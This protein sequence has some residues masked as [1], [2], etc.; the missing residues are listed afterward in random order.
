MLTRFRIELKTNR[1]MSAK[2]TNKVDEVCSHCDKQCSIGKLLRCGRC[3][4]ARYCD[5]KCQ[6]QAWTTHKALCQP[7]PSQ[8]KIDR[9]HE[10]AMNTVSKLKMEALADADIPPL[11]ITL[12]CGRQVTIFSGVSLPFDLSELPGDFSFFMP[13]H[14][15][16]P[17]LFDDCF[18]LKVNLCN[19]LKHIGCIMNDQNAAWVK[20]V[21]KSVKK[22]SRNLERLF[23]RVNVQLSDDN[24]F[25]NDMTGQPEAV[26]IYEAF[27]CDILLLVAHRYVHEGA[28]M[29]GL[30]NLPGDTKYIKADTFFKLRLPV[31]NER[32]GYLAA[33]RSYTMACHNC[34]NVHP[35]G[36]GLQYCAGCHVVKYCSKAC[37][38]ASWREQHKKECKIMAAVAV[39]AAA[40]ET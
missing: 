8:E 13:M 9:N 35:S 23:S 32:I 19:W 25:F 28:E 33:H 1:K 17:D 16:L 38:R 26:K 6:A 11:E 21:T 36:A 40:A 39:A 31:F 24:A 2:A 20:S 14:D 27:M 30:L 18:M 5:A 34:R 12:E 22:W 4:L 29:F 37:Q 3:R 7:P 10:R 15:L